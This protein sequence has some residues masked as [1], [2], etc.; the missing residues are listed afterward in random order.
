M[1]Q[2]KI[3]FLAV[4]T[5]MMLPLLASAQNESESESQPSESQPIDRIV[6]LVEED[7]ILQSELE[8]AI[9]AIEQQVQSRGQSL[10][11]RSVMEEQV[12]ERLIMQRLQILR[13]EQTG[14][15]VSD[16]DVDNALNRVAQQN[17]MSL[18]R[19][20]QM[21]EADG[22][23][24]EEFRRE[25]R[26][27]IITSRLQQRVVNS[28]DEISET[29]IDI[30]LASDQIDSQEYLLSQIVVQVP[31]SASP[32]QVRQAQ[33]RVEEIYQQLEDGMTFSA[34]AISYSQGSDAL[35]G[36]DVGWRSTNALPR[37]FVEAV[38]G[39]EPGTVTEPLRT[40]NG[41]VILK[42]RD[43]R[44]RSEVMVQEYRARHLVIGPSELVTPEEAREQA[45]NL[46]RRI[47][48]GEDFAELAREYSSDTSTANIGGL[49][50]WFPAGGYGRHIQEKVESLEPGEVS[51]PFRSPQGWHL[52]KLLDVR[53][54]DRTEEIR[55]EE[56]REMIS[57]QKSQ[58]EVDR[59]MRQLRSESFVEIRL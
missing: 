8:E 33:S 23:E 15:R 56:A 14:I 57:E 20:R 12:L 49:L 6:A 35:E 27:E 25:I 24:F 46:K 30:A 18:S 40:Q 5:L 43:V 44:E 59:F 45:Q 47:E 42:V 48:E 17:N 37:A 53:E 52:V 41:F 4:G 54:A 22:V 31:P 38:E 36:G 28:M 2:A 51:E 55:R 3:L 34:A 16:A 1:K 21:L 10:P 11:P 50:D 29:E 58:E 32:E 13:A 9:D 39:A 26:N 19:L 7:V